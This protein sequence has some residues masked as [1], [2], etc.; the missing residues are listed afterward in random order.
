MPTQSNEDEDLNL[1]CDAYWDAIV[2]EDDLSETLV[3]QK[4]EAILT[5]CKESQVRINEV[6]LDVPS[7]YSGSQEYKESLG[8]A[9]LW[10]FRVRDGQVL[11]KWLAKNP[12]GTAEEHASREKDHFKKEEASCSRVLIRIMQTFKDAG[13]D[14][15]QEKGAF[16]WQNRIR[17]EKVIHLAAFLNQQSIIE[18]LL[19]QGISLLSQDAQER[20]ALHYASE[21]HHFELS[22]WLVQKGIPLE[23][24]DRAGITPLMSFLSKK[25]LSRQ[26]DDQNLNMVRFLAP[27]GFSSKELELTL[28]PVGRLIE[29]KWDEAVWD[30]LL[31]RLEKEPLSFKHIKQALHS[32]N[33]FALKKLVHH[34]PDL[35]HGKDAQGMS[36]LHWA[37]GSGLTDRVDLLMSLGIHVHEKSSDQWTALH[38]LANGRQDNL[39][40]AETLLAAGVDIQAIDSLGQTVLHKTAAAGHD[41]MMEVFLKKGLEVDPIDKAGN[42]PLKLAALNGRLSAVKRLMDEKADV[43]VLEGVEIENKSVRDYLEGVLTAFTEKKMLEGLV[44]QKEAS[45]VGSEG[46]PISKPKSI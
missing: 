27:E 28:S 15:E 2:C 41:K 13:L 29:Y 38:F 17:K 9:T 43:S 44:V 7:Y 12:E 30:L 16:S 20:T 24:E 18:W 14:L 31:D 36:L 45:T 6:L 23:Q 46:L 39:V 34:Q 19:E 21:G 1:A 42:T 8:H 4:V 22:Q 26:G 3:L 11:E 10:A 25:S 37:A 32:N 33:V 40:I 5:L 35:L